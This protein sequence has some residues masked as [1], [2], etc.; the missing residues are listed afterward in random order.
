[1]Q[2]ID[3]NTL[4]DNFFSKDTDFGGVVKTN[5]RIVEATEGI[6]ETDRGMVTRHNQMVKEN[7]AYIDSLHIRYN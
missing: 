4:I 1:M 3:V 6:L 2:H 5:R 7:R